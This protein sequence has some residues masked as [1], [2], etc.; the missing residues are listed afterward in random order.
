[1]TRTYAETVA[2]VSNYIVSIAKPVVIVPVSNL[3]IRHSKTLF[4]KFVTGGLADRTSNMETHPAIV[5]MQTI[6]SVYVCMYV[7]EVGG[8]GP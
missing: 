7:C 6:V 4:L 3:V 2:Q 1:M 5:G 8:F